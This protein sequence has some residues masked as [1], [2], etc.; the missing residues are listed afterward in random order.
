M[1]PDDGIDDVECG[2]E[3]IGAG[4]CLI[5]LALTGGWIVCLL[6]FLFAVLY[7]LAGGSK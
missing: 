3:A 1:F 6:S 7:L 4:T 2:R 5:T